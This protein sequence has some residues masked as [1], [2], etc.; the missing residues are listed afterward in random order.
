MFISRCQRLQ[1]LTKK[2]KIE[3]GI[4]SKKVLLFLL[5]TKKEVS[6]PSLKA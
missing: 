6:D 1:K 4:A 3:R 5:L 2:D